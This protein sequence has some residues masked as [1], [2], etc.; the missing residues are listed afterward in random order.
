MN[1]THYDYLR[2]SLGLF[3]AILAYR[4]NKVG[5]NPIGGYNKLVVG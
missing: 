4:A 1:D 2:V 5:K 3:G